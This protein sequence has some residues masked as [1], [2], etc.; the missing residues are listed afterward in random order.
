MRCKGLEKCR[1]TLLTLLLLVLAA[2]CGRFREA[3]SARRIDIETEEYYASAVQR[4]EELVQRLEQRFGDNDPSL[5]TPLMTLSMAYFRQERVDDSNETLER[6]WA[7]IEKNPDIDVEELHI[8]LRYGTLA[9][10]AREG[11]HLDVRAHLDAGTDIVSVDARG[12]TALHHAAARGNMEMVELLLDRG[13]VTTKR[14]R[15]RQTPLQHAEKHGHDNIAGVLKKAGEAFDQAPA[16]AEEPPAAP[17]T[18]END[19]DER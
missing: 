8:P 5:I 2:G 9:L 1:L 19:W 10:A 16:E 7:I 4:A 6:A 14:D 13:A 15:E 18:G 17:E 3:R 12:M 11:N